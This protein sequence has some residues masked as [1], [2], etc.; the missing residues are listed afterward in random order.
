M[1]RAAAPEDLQA[2]L[3]LAVSSTLFL[4]D[5]TPSLRPV[6]EDV[7][8]GRLGE[9]HRMALWS[10]PPGT[11][12]AG[13]V[14]FALNDM[15]YRTWDLLWISVS[16]SHQGQGVG[17][18]LIHFAEAQVAAAGGRMIVIDTSSKL[19]FDATHAFYRQR[20]YTEV[21]RIPDFYADGDSKVIFA[22]RLTQRAS[23]RPEK[24]L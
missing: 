3:D 5:E 23:G 13:A 20:G 1:L 10:D 6:F 9:H 21:A 24:Q 8:T 4:P 14:Y 16:L 19:K 2:L 17:S 12:P 18:Q 22:K 7:L 11:G 15:A